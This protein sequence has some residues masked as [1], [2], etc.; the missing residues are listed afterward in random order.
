MK[1]VFRLSW[2]GH[3]GPGTGAQQGQQVSSRHPESQAIW[4]HQVLASLLPP[5]PLPPSRGT[6][7]GTSPSC[8]LTRKWQ[9]KRGRNCPMCNGR[10]SS[11]RQRLIMVHVFCSD[12]AV[13]SV[14]HEHVVHYGRRPLGDTLGY[15][16]IQQN[17]GEVNTSLTLA[18]YPGAYTTAVLCGYPGL[19]APLPA[20]GVF[21][22]QARARVGNA[23]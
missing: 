21:Y 13:Q 3:P 16:G 15:F 1:A 17:C 8:S 7:R 14:T 6:T 10:S 22:R 4:F 20:L 18:G 2:S 11:E 5:V 12:P 19:S 23:S 9:R